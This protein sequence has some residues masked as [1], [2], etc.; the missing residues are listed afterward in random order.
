ME[1]PLPAGPAAGP[2]HMERR[3][4]AGC[5]PLSL[6]SISIVIPVLNAA[7]LLPGCLESI[8]RLERG[9]QG[10][11]IL[12]VDN[13]STDDT[14]SV[15]RER[16]ATVLT[17]SRP[18]PYAARN[19]GAA[20]ARGE[21][22][23]FT[24]ADCILD[25]GWAMALEAAMAQL[26]AV[27]GLSLGAAGGRI[28]RLVQERYEANLRGR[29]DAHPPRPVFDTRNAAVTRDMFRR[30]G[31]FD[32]RLDD[33]SDDLFGIAVHLSGG[34]V[35]FREEMRV[36]HI[37]PETLSAVWRRQVRHGRNIPP[38]LAFYPPEVTA[39]FPGISRHRW[40]HGPSPGRRMGR[41]AVAFGTGLAGAG[42]AG[43]LRLAL[44]VKADVAA[45]NIFELFNRIGT[46]H[47]MATAR[48]LS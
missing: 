31:G 25:S 28:A 24:D 32:A 47:G 29:A 48:P 16:G 1:R 11:E 9:G 43:A 5:R 18:G 12:V 4:E 36:T 3:D 21:I 20:A 26:D 14:A 23:A 37:H 44:D 7:R 45:R 41:A 39:F 46:V 30:V 10:L 8:R 17:E 19:R 15:A 13:G 27:C 6:P 42:L 2:S 40:L 34:R 38:V 22:I 35:G 33:F